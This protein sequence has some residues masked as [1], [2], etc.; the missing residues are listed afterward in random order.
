MSHYLTGE[1]IREAYLVPTCFLSRVQEEAATGADGEGIREAKDSLY[2]AEAD[3]AAAAVAVARTEAHE[4]VRHEGEEAGGAGTSDG[5]SCT[6]EQR[7]LL[8]KLVLEHGVG[9][10]ETKVTRHDYFGGMSLGECLV[11]SVHGYCCCRSPYWG[12]DRVSPRELPTI[13]QLG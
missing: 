6:R 13:L 8:Q 7:A 11:T 10:L 2:F 4:S 1:L 3:A 9:G 5:K 12:A